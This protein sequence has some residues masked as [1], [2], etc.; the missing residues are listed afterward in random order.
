M[1]RTR[2]IILFR[3]VTLVAIGFLMWGLG[4]LPA[5]AS[6]IFI[7]LMMPPAL[8]S[9]GFSLCTSQCTDD[10]PGG[11]LVVAGIVDGTYCTNCASLNGTWGMD[12]YP[13][14]PFNSSPCQSH[15]YFTSTV[16]CSS[17]YSSDANGVASIFVS[18]FFNLRVNGMITYSGG[19]SGTMVQ[20]YNDSGSPPPGSCASLGGTLGSFF[21][22]PGTG[23]CDTTACTMSVS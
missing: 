17:P 13:G 7:G 22:G 10:F 12:V 9:G 20:K 1:T 5:S 16:S 19:L 11:S 4:F 23:D 15:H 8:L 2:L 14:G 21:I 3:C 18:S 6:L